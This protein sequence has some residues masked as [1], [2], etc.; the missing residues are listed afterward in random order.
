MPL[1]LGFYAKYI[2]NPWGMHFNPATVLL[3]D[4]AIL[5]KVYCDLD[6]FDSFDSYSYFYW[7]NLGKR[8][9]LCPLIAFRDTYP[10]NLAQSS[11]DGPNRLSCSA[12]NL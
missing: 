10:V 2:L 5:F 1:I 6:V 3:M 8:K 7:Q 4:F 12:D 9:D 11:Y